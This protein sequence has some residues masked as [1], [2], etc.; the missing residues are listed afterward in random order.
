MSE[1]NDRPVDHANSPPED[2]ATAV[3]AE[4]R[5]IAGLI[6]SR[7]TTS[8][9]LLVAQASAYEQA[10]AGNA[11]AQMAAAVL[12]SLARD[13]LQQIHDLEAAL[14]PHTL[15]ALG[16]APALEVMAAQVMRRH[17]VRMVLQM[18]DR[19]E[20][21]PSAWELALF[22]MVQMAL[23]RAVYQASASYV[24]VHSQ[25]DGDQLTLTLADNGREVVGTD[26]LAPALRQLEQLGGQVA[27]G[28]S[29]VGHLD[30]SI[31]ATFAPAVQLTLRELDVL[32]L[33]VEGLSNKAIGDALHLSPRTINFHLDNIY[34][35]LGV[36]SRTEAAVLALRNGLVRRATDDPG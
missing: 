23:D 3:E 32:R 17:G 34:S 31:V 29:P 25:H 21:L 24:T 5:R 35:K 9:N 36:H 16:L 10:L 19:Q 13:V 1:Y 7:V 20:R 12:A 27:L 4:R 18:A 28:I 22:R 6:A 30:L 14:Y 2:A 26:M 8:V 15:E 33:L 11:Q